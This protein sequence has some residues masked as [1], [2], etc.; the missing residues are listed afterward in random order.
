MI[1]DS[2]HTVLRTQWPPRPPTSRP[3]IARFPPREPFLT[4]LPQR[5]LHILDTGM[6]RTSCITSVT[7]AVCSSGLPCIR[8]CEARRLVGGTYT[9]DALNEGCPPRTYLPYTPSASE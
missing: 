7:L 8:R 1:D 4:A 2:S 9:V 5:R 3:A 6:L